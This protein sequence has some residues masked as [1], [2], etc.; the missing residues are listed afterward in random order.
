[1]Y[2]AYIP[3]PKKQANCLYSIK[4]MLFYCIPPNNNPNRPTI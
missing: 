1:M 3:E 4:G 2:A